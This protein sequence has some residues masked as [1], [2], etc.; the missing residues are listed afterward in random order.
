MAKG[1]GGKICEVRDELMSD[2]HIDVNA[3]TCQAF[4]CCITGH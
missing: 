4:L 1:Q 3:V 2:I